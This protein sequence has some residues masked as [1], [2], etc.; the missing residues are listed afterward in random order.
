MFPS[1]AAAHSLIA[2]A[3]PHS[4]Q[5]VLAK[6]VPQ[7]GHAAPAPKVSNAFWQL[8]QTQYSPTGGAALQDGHTKPSRRGALARRDSA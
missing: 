2:L 3:D 7:C 5:D 1:A 6:R 4:K 8:L